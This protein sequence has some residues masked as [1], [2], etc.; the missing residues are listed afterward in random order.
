LADTVAAAM[1]EAKPGRQSD[2]VL[3]GGEAPV[4]PGQRAAEGVDYSFGESAVTDSFDDAVTDRAQRFLD[5]APECTGTIEIVQGRSIFGPR[6][7]TR[8]RLEWRDLA[9]DGRYVI[10]DQHPPVATAVDTTK[11]V[12]MINTRIAA[13]VRAIKDE[14]R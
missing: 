6:G 3:P 14:R 1:P 7:M 2:L 5:T 12:A 11:L 13:I 8:H 10:D 4:L 9:D